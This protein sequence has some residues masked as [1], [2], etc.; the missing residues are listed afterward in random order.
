MVWCEWLEHSE[1]KTLYLQY[2]PLPVTGYHHIWHWGWDS[3]PRTNC[4]AFSFQDWYNKPDSITSVWLLRLGNAPSYP[5]LM[6]LGEILTSLQLYG[7]QHC[8]RNK[9]MYTHTT[10]SRRVPFLMD[11][12]SIYR[13]LNGDYRTQ[14][15][16]VHLF[17]Y[18]A[19]ATR[20]LQNKNLMVSRD[21]LE[22]SLQGSSILCST[23]WAT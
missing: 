18:I 6:R 10:L 19:Y 22:Q 20:Y 4:F 12:L 23:N 5:K 17:F 8:N 15:L 16:H 14:K 1:F 7:A 21:W 11:L 2:S 9:W 13:V 3:N